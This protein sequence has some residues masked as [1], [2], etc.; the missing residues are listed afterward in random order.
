RR[1]A[2]VA[3][4][5]VEQAKEDCRASWG[6]RFLE[7]LAQDVRYGLRGLGRSPGFTAA[8][9]VTLGLGIGANTAVFSLVNGVLLKPLP[10]GRGEQVVVLRQEDARSATG[11]LGFS[12]LEI[13][14]YREMTKSFDGLVEYHSMDFTLLGGGEAR[15]V[16]TGVVSAAFFD[17]L[18]VEP[19]LGRTFRARDE[20]PGADAVLLMSYAHSRPTG[21]D[22]CI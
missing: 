14:D 9:V 4:G 2:L 16:R 1:A 22:T 13:R 5:G 6:G 19:F 18:E 10:Y 8:V 11:N 21:S 15:R 17:V 20:A 12:P 7:V 3:F